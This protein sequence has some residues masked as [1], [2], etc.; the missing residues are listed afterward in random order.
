M[1]TITDDNI[2]DFIDNYIYDKESLP[3]DLE[4]IP[5]GNWNVS[6]VTNMSTLFYNLTN[7]NESLNNWDVSNVTNMESMF[8]YTENF[9]Q[10]LDQW[11]V[12]RVQDMSHIFYNAYSFNQ[13]INSWNVSNVQNMSNMF[14]N[15]IAFNQSINVW[16]VGSVVDMSY[17]FSGATNFNQPLNDWNVSRVEN[18]RKMFAGARS[19]N[20][21]LNRW[22]VSRVTDMSNMF[23]N[24]TNFNQPLD[25]WNVSQVSNMLH[26]FYGA[27]SFNQDLDNWNVQSMSFMTRIFP[28]GMRRPRWYQPVEED[29]SQTLRPLP[30]ISAVE[31]A[32]QNQAARKARQE[33][34]DAR[35]KELARLTPV[36]E[37]EFPTCIVCDDPLDNSDGPGPSRKCSEDCNDAVKVCPNG[38]ILHRGCILGWCN[39]DKVNQ[40]AQ[41]GYADY[42]SFAE[43]ERR[44]RCPVCLSQL[45]KPCE[46]FKSTILTP[47]ISTEELKQM[48]QIEKEDNQKAGRKRRYSRK[49]RGTKRIF[50]KRNGGK[51]IRRRVRKNTYRRK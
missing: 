51:T 41:M 33:E 8:K 39:A 1:T 14:C 43:Q 31:Q 9:N 30:M 49:K 24:A 38:H 17:M 26:M 11:N 15:A 44:D 40:G 29:T 42:P 19:F 25:N 34:I 2:R 5:I 12:S 3:S 45:I 16:D 35:V 21:P 23:N 10:P 36:M 32:Q 7:F 18:M 22:N 28:V 4:N 46:E 27:N 6:R 50:K 47:A 20:Q 13:P 37:N 48:K